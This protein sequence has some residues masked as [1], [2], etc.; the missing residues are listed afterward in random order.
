MFSSCLLTHVPEAL[1]IEWEDGRL[2]PH[3]WS[4][5]DF[6]AWAGTANTVCGAI[7]STH[8]CSLCPAHWEALGS[9]DDLNDR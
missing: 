9:L 4:D 8:R 6:V 5:A 2:G 3:W 7:H 1:L